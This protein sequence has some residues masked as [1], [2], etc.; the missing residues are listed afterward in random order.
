VP[1][2]EI[3]RLAGLKLVAGMPVETFIQTTPRTVASYLIRPVR[4]Q[5]MHSARNRQQILPVRS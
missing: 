1:E 2:R 5:M 4:D 3:S